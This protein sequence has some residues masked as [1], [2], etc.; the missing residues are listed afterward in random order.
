MT[1][2]NW[3]ENPVGRWILEVTDSPPAQ[4]GRVNSGLVKSVTLTLYG[5]AS[6]SR[7]KKTGYEN[8]RAYN[9]EDKRIKQI[10][11]QEQKDSKAVKINSGNEP[12]SINP[13]I[14]QRDDA[15]NQRQD[16]ETERKLTADEINVLYD[17][18]Q[19]RINE[20]DQRQRLLHNQRLNIAKKNDIPSEDDVSPNENSDVNDDELLKRLLQIKQNELRSQRE[21]DD[22][23][24]E[25]EGSIQKR[26]NNERVPPVPLYQNSPVEEGEKADSRVD[27]RALLSDDELNTIIELSELLETEGHDEVKRKLKEYIINSKKWKRKK[28]LVRRE[29]QEWYKEYMFSD[30]VLDTP[31]LKTRYE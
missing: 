6:P 21:D 15:T 26:G 31:V 18:I 14:K 4:S 16:T 1:V 12:T 20:I 25:N 28:S 7:E 13:L 30:I 23:D 27:D 3:G 22:D 11:N 19:R 8:M 9:P 24:D 5:T 2:F 29:Y 10:L 17:A